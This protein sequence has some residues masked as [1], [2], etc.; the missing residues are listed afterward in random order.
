MP[1]KDLIS[2][3]WGLLP[4]IAISTFGGLVRAL[5]TNFT[6]KSACVAMTVAAFTGV[7]VSLF[8]Q[9]VDFLSAAQKA[10]VTGIASY[11]GGTLL[12][13]LSARTCNLAKKFDKVK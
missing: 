1:E 7:V 13:I 4:A 3:L 2:Q 8:L 6:F 5:R 9:D 11:S 10:A 12:D